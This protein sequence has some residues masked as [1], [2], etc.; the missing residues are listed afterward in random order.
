LKANGTNQLP[1]ATKP[2]VVADG[3]GG[4]YL[5]W[6]SLEG[7]WIKG[8][9][10][11][12]DQDGHLLWAE[13]GVLVSTNTNTMQMPSAITCLPAENRVVVAWKETDYDQ[14]LIGLSAQSFD[15]QAT[16]LW[17]ATGL[18]VTKAGT[19]AAYAAALRPT[20]T[21]AGLFFAREQNA[22]DKLTAHVAFLPAQ[23]GA[24]PVQTTL[25][26]IPS[27]KTDPVVSDLVGGGYWLAWADSRGGIFGAFWSGRP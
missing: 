15:A 16:P 5:A 7:D 9:V 3:V 21:G 19:N 11:H 14:N 18:V 2:V 27:D 22:F 24:K 12:V 6:C 1:F 17:A 10:Q 8:R 23:P 20:S 26:R 4:I 13:D 25:S